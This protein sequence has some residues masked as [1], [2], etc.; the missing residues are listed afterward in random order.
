MRVVRII[1]SEMRNEMQNSRDGVNYVINGGHSQK[2]IFFA[3]D[4]LPLVSQLKP[5]YKRNL[6]S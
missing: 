6:L 5:V 1:N 3:I 2:T 4:I